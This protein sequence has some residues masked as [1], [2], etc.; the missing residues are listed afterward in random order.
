MK[1]HINRGLGLLLALVLTFFGTAPQVFAASSAKKAKYPASGVYRIKNQETGLYLDVYSI[2]YDKKGSAHL[3]DPDGSPAQD[4]YVERQPD[5]SYYIY[6]QNEGGVYALSTSN[7]ETVTKTKTV[8]AAEKFDIYPSG[9]GY[10]ICPAYSGQRELA[11]D[12]SNKTSPYRHGYVGM[13][14]YSVWDDGQKWSFEAVNTTGL[15]MAYDNV[16]VKLNSTGSFYATVAPYNYGKHDIKW[17]SSDPDV[18]LVSESGKYCALSEGT[19]LITATCED[20]ITSCTVTVS[21]ISAFTWYSQHNIHTSDWDG[22]KLDGIYFSSGG[23]RKRFAID[24]YA[25]GRDW[26]DEGCYLCSVAMVLNNLGATMT[27]G[28]DFRSGQ[29]NNLSPDPYTVALANSGN[30]GATTGK[31][32]LYGNPILVRLS[33]I[34]KRF[35][36]RGKSISSTQ[37]NRVSAKAIKEALD[38]HPEGVIVH[39]TMGSKSHYIVFTRCYNPEEKD[40]SKYRFEVSD[41]AAYSRAEGDHVPFESCTS[42]KW[43]HYRLGHARSIITLNVNN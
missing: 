7:G 31:E 37:V 33:T 29:R 26:L 21:N 43:E 27:S 20:M 14:Q 1:K 42:Y 19:A 4:F 28:Y 6:P 8:T 35:T 39:F 13:S 5:G 11:L 36:V 40:P 38:M 30:S 41:S 15:S 12:V 10:T 9:R 16:T 24:R 22:S 18:V 32:T 23:A 17:T 2:A 34:L 3:T 25:S